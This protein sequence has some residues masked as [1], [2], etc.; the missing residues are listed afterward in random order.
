MLD[1]ISAA[2][3]PWTIEHRVFVF[4]TFIQTGSSVVLYF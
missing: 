3:E 4:E 1:A 2:M